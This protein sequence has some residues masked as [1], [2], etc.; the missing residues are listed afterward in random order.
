M[1]TN[2]RSTRV[3]APAT[4]VRVG[5]AVALLLAPLLA[6]TPAPV[7]AA[8]GPLSAQASTVPADE[9]RWS[10]QPSS[11]SGPNGRSEFEYELAPGERISD[12]LAISNLTDGPLTVDVYATDA[13][14]APDG[15]FAL[16]PAA[17]APTGAGAWLTVPKSAY[18]L[19]AGK[20]ADIP[21]QLTVPENATPGDHIGGLIASV[22]TDETQPG[23]QTIAVERRI[24]ARVYLRV[25]GPADPRAL[26]TAVDVDYAA[27]PLAV[28]GEDLTVTYRIAN[29]GNVRFSGT[30]RVVVT[31]PL[32]IRLGTSD[33]IEIPELLPDSELRLTETL[34]SVLPAGW[35]SAT[36]TV[37]P[38]AGEDPL[39]QLTGSASM[40]AVPWLLIVIVGAGGLIAAGLWWRRRRDRA[41]AAAPGF[42]DDVVATTHP[43]P[44]S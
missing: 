26:I 44:A 19:P 24:A 25:A 43:A 34:P 37:N 32:G 35:I 8:P 33:T 1:S 13:F 18:T 4:P 20:R 36:L 5:R 14:T 22:T 38:Q 21:F 6:L 2:P 3:L 31:G 12:W 28:P 9:F 23:G 10:V 29:D 16:L 39:P 41:L 42:D 7:A 40:W 17:D 11:P 27:P 15:G 30:A